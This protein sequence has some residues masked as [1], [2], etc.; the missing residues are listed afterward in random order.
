MRLVSISCKEHATPCG[1]LVQFSPEVMNPEIFLC[2][3]SHCHFCPDHFALVNLQP[4]CDT[5]NQNDHEISPC[6][7]VAVVCSPVVLCFCCFLLSDWRVKNNGLGRR[8]RDLEFL[9]EAE[10]SSQV[11]LS[12]RRRTGVPSFP[13][14]CWCSLT[15]QGKMQG[16]HFPCW[17][18][19]TALQPNGWHTP[20]NTFLVLIP[21]PSSMLAVT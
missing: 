13:N 15:L 3:T 6:H 18:G 4:K 21:I 7:E 9:Q 17:S 19:S 8:R 14:P 2:S 10:L 5:E 20:G 16:Q 1:T 11:F 12:H